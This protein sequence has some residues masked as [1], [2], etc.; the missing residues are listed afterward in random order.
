VYCTTDDNECYEVFI[1]DAQDVDIF[2]VLHRS[3]FKYCQ[4]TCREHM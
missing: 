4:L 1:S 3:D 2:T